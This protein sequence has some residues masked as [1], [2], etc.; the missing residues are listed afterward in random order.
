MEAL[1]G[2]LCLLVMFC[3]LI[4]L[5]YIDTH[6]CVYFVKPHV[7]L[8]LRLVHLSYACLTKKFKRKY[9]LQGN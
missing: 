9:P 5:T 7:A 6:H 2:I 1:R 4:V 3:V 8:H